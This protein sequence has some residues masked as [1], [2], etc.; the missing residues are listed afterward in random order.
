ME[1]LSSPEPSPAPKEEEEEEEETAA[2]EDVFT[3]SGREPGNSNSYLRKSDTPSALLSSEP[4]SD[5]TIFFG[6]DSIQAPSPNPSH[7]P[8]ID[9]TILDDIASVPPRVNNDNDRGEG[10]NGCPNPPPHVFCITLYKPVLCR[11]PPDNGRQQQQQ[12]TLCEYTN[13]CWAQSVGF[14]GEVDCAEKSLPG[15]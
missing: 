10:D 8:T 6:G 3:E 15:F 13:K 9:F 4:F 1:S 11:L 2:E 12:Q 5:S 7:G 14:D